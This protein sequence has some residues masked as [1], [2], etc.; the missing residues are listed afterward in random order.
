MTEADKHLSIIL[1]PEEGGDSRTFRVSRRR[2]RAFR[3]G[4]IALGSAAVFMLGSWPFLVARSARVE[5]LEDQV[6]QLHAEQARVRTLTRIVDDLED[7]YE[8]LRSLFGYE[9][10][11]PASE[12]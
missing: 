11:A 4:G 1:V 9:G 6:A 10:S 12:M 8:T 3:L 5:D 2:L 7:R